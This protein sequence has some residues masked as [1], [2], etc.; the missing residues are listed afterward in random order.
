MGKK[1]TITELIAQ[2][3]QLKQKT[4][5]TLTLHIESLQGE[6]VI[7]EPS[8]A[9]ALEA[10]EMAQD[11]MKREM[12]DPF[13]VYNCVIEPNLKDPELLKAYGCV[14]PTDIVDMIFKPGEIGAISGHALQLA[15]YGDGVKKMIT[16][17]KN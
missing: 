5:R 3:E 11:D 1:L 4:K 8:R 7:E 2:K 10:I 14:E 16:D 13:V 17:L 12:S 9:L 15:G 6:I